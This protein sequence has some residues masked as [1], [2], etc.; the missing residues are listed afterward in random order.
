MA[1]TRLDFY[2]GDQLVNP[3]LNWRGTKIKASF[4]SEIQPAIETETFNYV[5]EAAK[6]I[7][8][9]ANSGLNGGPGM[10][11]GYPKKINI[12]KGSTTY[13]AFDGFLDFTD[14]FRIINSVQVEAKAK[15]YAGAN[16]LEEKAAGI[17]FGYLENIGHITDS[18]YTTVEKV[19]EKENNFLE[20]AMTGIITYLMLKE[21]AEAIQR[22]QDRAATFSGILSGS[23]TG[24]VGAAVYAGLALLVEAAYTAL[25]IGYVIAL[26]K[27]IVESFISPIIKDKCIS[28]RRALE[29]G[30]SFLGYSLSTN[31][32]DLDAFHFYPSNP[33][34]EDL[35][36]RGMFK[37]RSITS[38]VPTSLDFGYSFDE[39]LAVIKRTFRAKIQVEG[40]TVNVYNEYDEFWE[41]NSTYQMPDVLIESEERNTEEFRQSR[42]VKYGTDATDDWTTINFKGTVYEVIT[43]PENSPDP[44]LN[45]HKGLEQI[46]IPYALGNRKDE[47]NLIE[48][49]LSELLGLMDGLMSVFGVNK[50]LKSL[51]TRRVG[52][53]KTWNTNHTVAKRLD[54]DWETEQF[55]Q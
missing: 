24:G 23:I 36:I 33:K 53:L 47:L 50:N 26:A 55:R 20:I 10:F 25:M 11:I 7:V 22:L 2:L 16:T 17:T 4:G 3:P 42:L 21:I 8:T 35:S 49:S 46:S 37:R 45:R 44:R 29:K 54:R 52:M 15:Q 13:N 28:Y 34:V 9:R 43:G 27:Q 1:K 6:R 5:N 12:T 31:I 32:S 38:G 40:D 14:E 39:F 19:V 18:D 51:V 30:L 41:Q 48:R